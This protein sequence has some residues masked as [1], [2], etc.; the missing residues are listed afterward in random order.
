MEHLEASA[1]F[2]RKQLAEIDAKIAELKPKPEPVIPKPSLLEKVVSLSNNKKWKKF[3]GNEYGVVRNIESILEECYEF[4]VETIENEFPDK[5]PWDVI[6]LVDSDKW[7]DFKFKTIKKLLDPEN[8]DEEYDFEDTANG[9]D[10]VASDA[11]H[12]VLMELLK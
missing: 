12:E 2:L 7:V 4:Y 9:C 8:F 6:G 3:V 5:N 10:E 1:A 11:G